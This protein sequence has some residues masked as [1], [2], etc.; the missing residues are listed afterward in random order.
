M[1]CQRH[2]FAMMA[3]QAAEVGVGFQPAEKQFDVPALAIQLG[4]AAG[5][6][7]QQTAV[8]RWIH[9]HR[10]ISCP[11]ALFV[12]FLRPRL[13]AGR[14]HD[15]AP[16][17]SKQQTTQGE[18]SKIALTQIPAS[19]GRSRVWVNVGTLRRAE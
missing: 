9:A 18:N 16:N 14:V 6:S 10:Q 3:A 7:F 12:H 1:E 19:I 15:F 2:T 13:S 17:P 5:G 8:R 11:R 4:N